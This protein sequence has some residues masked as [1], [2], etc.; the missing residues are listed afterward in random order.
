ML[1]IAETPVFLVPEEK[2]SRTWL[3]RR[4]RRKSRRWNGTGIVIGMEERAKS[5]SFNMLSAL[6]RLFIPVYFVCISTTCFH[7]L[8][9]VFMSLEGPQ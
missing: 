7:A 5:T 2:I 6:V 3:R 8:S 4:W 9:L 1:R